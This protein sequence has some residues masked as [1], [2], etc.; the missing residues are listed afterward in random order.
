MP[1]R[2]HAANVES[3]RN[4]QKGAT[5]VEADWVNLTFGRVR[6][7]W[8]SGL[9]P[10]LLVH[11]PA[12]DVS[13]VSRCIA[14]FFQFIKGIEL[15]RFAGDV[16]IAGLRWCSGLPPCLPPPADFPPLPHR[17]RPPR[18]PDYGAEIA[19]RLSHH[20]GWFPIP[21]PQLRSSP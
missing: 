2:C 9:K 21:Q 18:S 8:T 13:D 20:E 17:L 6:R 10:R 14:Q 16:S 5:E 4:V 3:V 15:T 12:G 11:A 19:R 7:K 1:T